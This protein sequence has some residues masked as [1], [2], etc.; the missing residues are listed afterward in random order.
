VTAELVLIISIGTAVLATIG[1]DAQQAICMP[2]DRRLVGA[3]F[4]MRHEK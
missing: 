4:V 3:A 2:L 1:K